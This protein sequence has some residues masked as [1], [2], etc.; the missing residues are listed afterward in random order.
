M[1]LTSS[2]AKSPSGRAPRC[3]HCG[4][5]RFESPR[6][7]QEVGAFRGDFLR[8]RIVGHSSG[9]REQRSS[10]SDKLT[11]PRAEKIFG[12]SKLRP[13]LLSST[14]RSLGL[15]LTLTS[16]PGSGS[17]APFELN[18]S[19]RSAPPSIRTRRRR[20]APRKVDV[21]DLRVR[22]VERSERGQVLEWLKAD[23]VA[24][25][26]RKDSAPARLRAASKST[27]RA[28]RVVD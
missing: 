12:E 7:H 6:L 1:R 13:H 18:A 21:R 25:S 4:G 2:H 27:G 23:D 22:E 19:T 3:L 20:I 28:T 10:A 16:S 8:H 26:R 15:K 17:D 11:M 5:Q 24:S 9:L 14:I